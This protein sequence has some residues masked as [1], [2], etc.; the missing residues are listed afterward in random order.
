[1][2][3]HKEDFGYIWKFFEKTINWLY[4]HT[5]YRILVG[6]L[7]AEN[8]R[9]FADTE[10][11]VLYRRP[12][13][14]VFLRQSLFF[15]FILGFAAPCL[16][17]RSDGETDKLFNADVLISTL[18][19]RT[20]EE[21]RFCEYVIQRRDEG[22][23][24]HRIIYGVYRKAITQERHRRFTYFRAGLEIVCQ[25]EGIVLN[26]NSTRRT[27]GTASAL[28]SFVPSILRVLFQRS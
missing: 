17:Q 11:V 24:P 9:S 23:I 8:F 4:H 5:F 25:R 14:T 26:P 19:A 21:K 6:V 18:F 15:L 22:T 27:P 7:K 20:A 12:S 2:F 10:H 1:M 28:P 13:E 16:A 3:N